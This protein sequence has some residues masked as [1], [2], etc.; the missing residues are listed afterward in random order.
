MSLEGC[1][2]RSSYKGIEPVFSTSVL[3][4]SYPK[5]RRKWER[6]RTRVFARPLPG[7]TIVDTMRFYAK[8]STLALQYRKMMFALEDTRPRVYNFLLSR[9]LPKPYL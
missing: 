4:E 9:G 7:G 3:E 6:M 1:F 8:R 2:E 5:D